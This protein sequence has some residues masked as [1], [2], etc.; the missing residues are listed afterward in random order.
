MR[1][2]LA[3]LARR[4]GLRVRFDVMDAET[5]ERPGGLCKIHGVKTVVVDAC[6]PALDQV[7]VLLRVLASYNLDVVYVPPLLRKRICALQKRAG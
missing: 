7:G 2:R 5:V 4:M 6:A 3:D 1:D